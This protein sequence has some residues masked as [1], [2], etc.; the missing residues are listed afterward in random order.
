MGQKG[1]RAAE[2]PDQ[3]PSKS[4]RTGMYCDHH[5]V[6][7]HSSKECRYKGPKAKGSESNTDSRKKTGN[8]KSTTTPKKVHG[9][10]STCDKAYQAL[11]AKVAEMEA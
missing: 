7:T 5:K 3:G 11:E 6:T 1:K 8:T 10:P 2:T 9:G 4:P